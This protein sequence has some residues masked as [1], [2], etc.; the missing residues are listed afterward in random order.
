MLKSSRQ[1]LFRTGDAGHNPAMSDPASEKPPSKRICGQHHHD[2]A[3]ATEWFQTA[4]LKGPGRQTCP[5]GSVI[6]VQKLATGGT[7]F[8]PAF[9]RKQLA[10]SVAKAL[11]CNPPATKP[12]RLVTL[13][14]AGSEAA[15]PDEARSSRDILEGSIIEQKGGA[16]K[17]KFYNVH[18]P[19]IRQYTNAVTFK[20]EADVSPV[21]YYTE[22]DSREKNTGPLLTALQVR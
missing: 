8:K 20:L 18:A 3:G 11:A 19:A 2:T 10:A 12:C 9:H 13:G 14:T 7:V 17:M 15:A 16:G 5:Y 1:Q 6:E 4:F 21:G 22:D